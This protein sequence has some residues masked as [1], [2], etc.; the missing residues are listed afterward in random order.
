L[1]LLQLQLS[2][3]DSGTHDKPNARRWR[4]R[5]HCNYAMQTCANLPDIKDGRQL[6]SAGRWRTHASALVKSPYKIWPKHTH[7]LLEGIPSQHFGNTT[8][9][10]LLTILPSNLRIRHYN[11]MAQRWSPRGH[12]LPPLDQGNPFHELCS[13]T[14]FWVHSIQPANSRIHQHNCMGLLGVAA[15]LASL[16]AVLAGLVAEVAALWGHTHDGGPCNTRLSYQLPRC[17]LRPQRN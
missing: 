13:T 11:R 17:F 8:L 10:W 1:S 12:T 9:S 14:P 15:L 5:Q 4:M 6:P 7:R 3:F 2:S 16:V